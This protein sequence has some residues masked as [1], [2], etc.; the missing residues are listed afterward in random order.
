L[1]VA[2]PAADADIL[3]RLQEQRAPGTT[4]NLRRSRAM[5]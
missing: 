2:L 1:R 5:T 4:A 3:D